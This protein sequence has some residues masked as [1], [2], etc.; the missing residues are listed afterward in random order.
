GAQA[1]ADAALA[2]AAQS[3]S[4]EPIKAGD[5]PPG[6]SPTGEPST[7]GSAPSPIPEDVRNQANSNLVQ[8]NHNDVGRPETAAAPPAATSDPNS[9]PAGNPTAASPAAPSLASAL[10]S[11][12]GT[13][14]PA[15]TNPAGPT[16]PSPSPA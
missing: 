13:P 11:V 8:V 14:P 16:P 15:G 1:E 2:Q 10:A 9:K 5:T 12:V 6:N 7:P 4:P 3:G